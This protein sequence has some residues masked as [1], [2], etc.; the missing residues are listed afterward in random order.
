YNGNILVTDEPGGSAGADPGGVWQVNLT[1]GVQTILTHGGY[2]VHATDIAM[3]PSGN[4]ITMGATSPTDYVGSIVRLNPG[5]GVQTQVSHDGILYYLDGLT[6]DV[7]TGRIYTGAIS[8]GNIP[9]AMYAVDPV[10]GA[11]STIAQGGL[12]SLVEGIRVYHTIF[13]TASTTPVTS[14]ATPSVPGQSVTFTAAVTPTAGGGG[15]PTGTVQFQ[16]DGMNF[17]SPVSLR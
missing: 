10:T 1:T 13:Q 3:D 4:V 2:L 15:T 14:S 17:G 6:V 16:I 11:Q 7:S 9:A 8:T 5:T 12:M